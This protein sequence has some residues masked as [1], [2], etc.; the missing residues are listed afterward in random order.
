L[1]IPLAAGSA[2]RRT[3]T[4]GASTGQGGARLTVP[5]RGLFNF[6]LKKEASL[7]FSVDRS[8]VVAAASSRHGFAGRR[9]DDGHDA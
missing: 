8:G 3:A 5:E 2:R 1:L 7:A 9:C 6:K 4:T